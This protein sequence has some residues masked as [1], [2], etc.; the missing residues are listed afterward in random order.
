MLAARTPL[1]EDRCF[2]QTRATHLPNSPANSNQ[3]RSGEPSRWVCVSSGFRQVLRAPSKC[4]RKAPILSQ[5]LVLV[6]FKFCVD[7][8]SDTRVNSTKNGR[9]G[10]LVYKATL[11]WQGH[12]FVNRLKNQRSH[13]LWPRPP[14]TPLHYHLSAFLFKSIPLYT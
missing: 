14:T 4:L 8:S 1:R 9:K 5:R 12:S 10:T 2:P 3:Q 13:A 11:L 7:A 6:V